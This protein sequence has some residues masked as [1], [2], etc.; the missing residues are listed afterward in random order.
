VITLVHLA[1]AASL[2]A[3]FQG[4]FGAA[5]TTRG[6]A[7][8]GTGQADTNYDVDVI[9]G[10]GLSANEGRFILSLGYAPT[11]DFR[12][13]GTAESGTV[14]LHSGYLSMGYSERGFSVNLSQSASVGTQAFRG[15]QAAPVDPKVVPNPTV[16]RVD[17]LPGNQVVR[18]FNEST[19][20]TVGYRWDPRVS[21]GLGAS[22]SI[23][24]GWGDAAQAT[25]PQIRT[26]LGDVNTSYQITTTDTTGASLAVSNIRTHG[27]TQGVDATGQPILALDHEFWTASGTLSWA[28][29]FSRVSTGSLSGGIY[30]YS[31][32]LPGRT[33]LYTLSFSGAGSYDT[34]LAREGRMVLTAGVGASVGPNVNTLSASL[35]QRVQG[36]GRM[37]LSMQDFSVTVNGDGSQTFPIDD[38]QAARV[39]GVGAG[40]SYAA[41]KFMDLGLD[42]RNT[43]QS[44]NVSSVAHLWTLFLT[45]SVRTPPVKF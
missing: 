5:A 13:V 39:V 8:S 2:W 40:A 26:A 29:R 3:A 32:K 25:L 1:S 37:T 19:G 14:V 4:V 16:S 20:A 9:P 45:V 7:R 33:T 31:T 17:L 36:T 23:G 11:F 15:L 35:Q 10:A 18:V 44:T 38:A 21:S 28:H 42:Y 34:E 27:G 43:W 12:N 30:G 22:Y 41:A 6:G 24:G